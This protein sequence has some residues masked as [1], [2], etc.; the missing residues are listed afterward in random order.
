MRYSSQSERRPTEL[1]NYVIAAL[2]SESGTTI[3]NNG[4]ILQLLS[5]CSFR[6]VEVPRVLQRCFSFIVPLCLPCDNS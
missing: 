5:V 2:L 4:L 6:G 3:D 1:S